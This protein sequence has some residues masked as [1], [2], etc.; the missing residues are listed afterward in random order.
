MDAKQL[1]DD[2]TMLLGRPWGNV[3]DY[4][5]VLGKERAWVQVMLADVPVADKSM[6]QSR[7]FARDVAKVMIMRQRMEDLRNE[8]R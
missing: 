3:T 5:K 2:L 6:K 1:G 4:A 8:Y 7:W